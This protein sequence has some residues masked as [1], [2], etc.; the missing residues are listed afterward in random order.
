MF[1]IKTKRRPGL[2]TRLDRTLAHALWLYEDGLCRDCRQPADITFDGRNSGEYAVDPLSPQCDSC[3]A[4]QEDAESDEKA[5]PGKKRRLIT[6][7]FDG[8]S[9][10]E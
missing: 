3:R 4:L 1:G 10:G 7:L 2:I 5:L 9:G 8:P 6:K